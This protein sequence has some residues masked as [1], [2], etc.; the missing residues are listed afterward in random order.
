V[1]QRG[2]GRKIVGWGVMGGGHAVMGGH[3]GH[4]LRLAHLPTRTAEPS[5]AAALVSLAPECRRGAWSSPG[6]VGV[7]EEKNTSRAGSE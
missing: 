7:A 6:D 4:N 5:A 2:A 1:V 3:A